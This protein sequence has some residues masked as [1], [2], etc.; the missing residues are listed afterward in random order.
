MANNI[1]VPCVMTFICQCVLHSLALYDE[2]CLKMTEY[3]FFLFLQSRFIHQMYAN[4]SYIHDLV[5]NI[6]VQQTLIM[7]Y[8]NTSLLDISIRNAMCNL[9]Q[10]DITNHCSKRGKLRKRKY[11]DISKSPKVCDVIQRIGTCSSNDLNTTQRINLQRHILYQAESVM[12][13]TLDFWSNFVKQKGK[14]FKSTFKNKRRRK[15]GRKKAKSS[16]RRTRQRG[17][18]GRKNRSRKGRKSKVTEKST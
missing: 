12:K 15:G 9:K 8:V 11:K 7:D 14:G 4:L 6:N 1:C 16:R 10:A 18:K 17:R 5:Q 2:F 3:Y 13:S